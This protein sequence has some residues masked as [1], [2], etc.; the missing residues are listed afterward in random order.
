MNIIAW[1]ILGI[2]AGALAKAIYPG[3]QG[4]GIISTIILGI[5]GAFIGGTI[6]TLL[7]TGT[8][9]LTSATFSLP[10]FLVAIVGAMIAIYLWEL[11]QRSSR[12]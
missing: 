6:F 4:G 1:I 7:S 9:Q 8:L 3:H 12:A 5:V 2:L 10:G 11:F